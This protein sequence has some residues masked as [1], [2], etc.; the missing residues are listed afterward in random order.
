MTARRRYCNTEKNCPGLRGKR[1]LGQLVFL[2]LFIELCEHRVADLIHVADYAV[3]A[4]VEDR[5]IRIGVD[6]NDRVRI[7]KA[8][9]VVHGARYAE[10]DVQ[11]WLYHNARLPDNELERQHAAVKHRPCA[12]KLSAEAL[13]E[14][15][16]AR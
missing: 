8:R 1:G 6:G 2:C 9:D 3:G 12:G 16:V 14:A 15:A 11:L 7:G 13:G 4:V 5:R 10:G